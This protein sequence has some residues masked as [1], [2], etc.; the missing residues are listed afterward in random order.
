MG[1][2]QEYLPYLPY[3][4]QGNQIVLDDGTLVGKMEKKMGNAL[5]MRSRRKR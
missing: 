1:V 5:A 2:M 3:L 4:A